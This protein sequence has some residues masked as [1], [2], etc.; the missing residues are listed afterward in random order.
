MVECVDGERVHT[1]YSAFNFVSSLLKQAKTRLSL[2]EKQML[3]LN[4]C[5]KKYKIKFEKKYDRVQ[6]SNNNKKEKE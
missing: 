2:S 3:A 6:I 4:K 1:R 5:Y